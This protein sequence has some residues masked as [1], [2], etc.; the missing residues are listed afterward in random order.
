M[1]SN[2]KHE[3]FKIAGIDILL[4]TDGNLVVDFHKPSSD[5]MSDLR[6]P[7]RPSYEAAIR[8]LESYFIKF[9]EE[10]EDMY[11]IK[12]VDVTEDEGDKI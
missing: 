2:D 10:L 4:K 7:D 9:N 3:I 8:L 1:P 11:G 12:A 5:V 6:H